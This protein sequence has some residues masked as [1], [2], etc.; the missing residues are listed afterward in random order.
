MQSGAEVD[1]NVYSSGLELVYSETNK[2]IGPLKNNSLGIYWSGLD[3]NNNKVGSGVYIFVIK[4]GDEV[5]KG[6]VVI[7]NE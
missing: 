2:S 3:N 6:K 7:F 4:Q 1:F 5:I